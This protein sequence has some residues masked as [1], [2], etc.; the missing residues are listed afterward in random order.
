MTT[1]YDKIFFDLDGTLSDSYNGI[2][3]GIRFALNKTG[4][5]EIPEKDIKKLI[6]SPLHES[7]TK[8]YFNDK[9]KTWKA[10]EYF[11]DY[12]D[13]KGIN[14]SQ[15]YPGIVDLL[16]ELSTISQLYVITAKPTLFAKKLLTYH[17]V[18]SLFTDILGCQME[19]GNF[20]KSGLIK[21]V[22]D[23]QYSIMI[24]D[25]PQ[26]IAAGKDVGIETGGVLYGYG[27]EEEII[28]SAPDFIINSVSELKRILSC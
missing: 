15:L 24:G 11:R 22:P 1:K 14:E 4:I 3:N 9:Q 23:L 18:A 25:K 7:L 16:Q 20:S 17:N 26:D 19:G 6:G 12:Y 2:E 27:T 8:Y 28:D 21:Q 5:T 13:N 10:V